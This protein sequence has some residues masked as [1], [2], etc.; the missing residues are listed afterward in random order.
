MSNTKYTR[1][2][3]LNALRGKPAPYVTFTKADG[4][5]RI[6]WC[7]LHEGYI[8]DAAKPKNEKPIKENNDVIRVYDLENEG[9]RSFRVDAVT[10]Y[11]YQVTR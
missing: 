1:D 5:E 6:M 3:L 2:E 10:H 11:G 7:T 4:T 8:P 9:W